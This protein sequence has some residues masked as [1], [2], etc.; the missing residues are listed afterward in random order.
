L[1][2]QNYLTTT[3]SRP[4]NIK[5][6]TYLQIEIPVERLGFFYLGAHRLSFLD[7][8]SRFPRCMPAGKAEQPVPIG[9]IIQVSFSLGNM[10][11]I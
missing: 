2:N 10:K 11:R 1:I 6:L 7:Q 9:A 4:H 8:S 3:G 5:Y